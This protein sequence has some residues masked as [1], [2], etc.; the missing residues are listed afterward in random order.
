METIIVVGIVAIV[1]AMAGRSLYRTMTG[2]NDGCGCISA[3]RGCDCTDVTKGFLK[4]I[5]RDKKE[6]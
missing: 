5:N 1:V 4:N 2:K 3:C 6:D